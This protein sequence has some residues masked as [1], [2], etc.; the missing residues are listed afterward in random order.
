M[1]PLRTQATASAQRRLL[2]SPAVSQCSMARGLFSCALRQQRCCSATVRPNLLTDAAHVPPT[3]HPRQ[4]RLHVPQDQGLHGAAAHQGG[5]VDQQEHCARREGTQLPQGGT[6][7][8]GG[9]FGCCSCCC[10]APCLENCS[11]SDRAACWCQPR[12]LRRHRQQNLASV[13]PPA[14]CPP[15]LTS[16]ACLHGPCLALWCRRWRTLNCA[17]LTP[18]ATA[19]TA[20]TGRSG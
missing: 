20:T 18:S 15:H 7:L 13:G 3:P 9:C 11:F 4:L 2:L 12:E 6:Q 5:A 14:L 17:P 10:R 1:Q 16:P 8:G 19:G